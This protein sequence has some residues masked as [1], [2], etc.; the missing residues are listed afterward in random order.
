MTVAIIGSGKMGSGFARLLASKGFDITIGN[1]NLQKAEAL[2]KEIGAEVKGG[3]VKDAVS[4]ADVILLAVKYEDASEALKAAGDLTNKTVIDISNPITADFKGLTIGH[5]TSAA[6]EIQ[7][8]APGAKVVKA[9]NTIFA[10]LLPTET[11]KGRKVQ[12]FIAG[13][14]ERAKAT[15]SNLV[16]ALEF[17][18]VESGTLYNSR[19]L[20]PMGEMNIWLGFFLGWGTSGAP[21]Y[22]NS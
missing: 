1:K 12:V 10:E 2:A 7:K 19:F 17:E 9:F 18:P 6:E 13:D 20:E 11:R 14:D 15:V 8:V 4:Q 5:S 3:S 21:E 16:K 22:R